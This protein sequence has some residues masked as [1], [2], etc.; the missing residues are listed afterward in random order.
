VSMR[1]AV[2]SA[3]PHVIAESRSD[4]VLRPVE[5]ANAGVFAALAVVIVSVGA[6]L[7]HLGA[8]ELLSVVP[9][10]IVGLRNRVRAV[11]AAVIAAA[12]VA[13][14]VAG[15]TATIVIAGCAVLG[16]FCGIIRR[17]G[18][19][20]G[21]VALVAAGLAPVSAA[22]VVGVLYLFSAARAL[23]FGTLRTS[24]VGIVRIAGSLRVPAPIG[25]AVMS[26]TDALLGA[27]PIAVAVVVLIAVPVGMLLTNA[28]VAGVARRV[29]WLA[30]T[31]LLDHAARTDAALGEAVAPVPLELAGVGFRHR[32]SGRDALV[33]VDLT[34]VPGEFIAVVGPNGAGKSTLVSLLAGAEPT[35]GRVR[36]PGR[37][38][39][40]LPGGT[41]IVAQRAETQVIGSTVGEDLRWGLP[42]G[43]PI[44][45]EALLA[46]VGLAGL[47]AASTESLSGGQ[48]Q[49]LAIATA[50]A[51]RP[52]LLISDEST[53]MLDAAGRAEVLDLLAA[54]PARTGTAV[55][56]VTHDPAEAARADRVI[57]LAD[58]RIVDAAAA[59]HG[60]I[61][62]TNDRVA[63]LA[64]A[65]S[66]AAYRSLA[67]WPGYT[68]GA[69]GEP[70]IRVRGVGHRFDAGTPWEVTALRS[71]DLD[72]REGEGLLITGENG[73]GKS[74][75]A[76]VLA[77]LIRPT[78]GT[79]TIDGAPA[80][81]SVG[82]VALSFQLARLQ[83]QRPTV[84]EDILA[85][86]GF[87]ATSAAADADAFVRTSLHRVGLPADLAG[88]TIDELSG[89]QMRR[90]AIAGLLASRPRVLILDEP[91]AGLDRESRRGLIELLGRMRRE[92]GLTLVVISHDFEDVGLACTRTI[93][94]IAGT[95]VLPGASAEPSGAPQPSRP[96][97]A[98]LVF[99]AVPGTSALHRLGAATKLLAMA[100]VTITS[101][102]L[103]GWPT[104]A[105][106]TILLVAGAAAARLPRTV[107][108]R[109]SWWVVAIV[110]L[111]GVTAAAGSGIVLY[112]RSLLLTVLFLA[113]SLLVVWTTRVEELPAA[114]AR[115]ARPLRKLGAPVDE[116]AHTLALAVRTLPL[117]RDEFRVLIAGRR[118]R[119]S[120]RA[121][122]RWARIVARCRELID[123]VVAIVASAGRRASDLGR[124]ATQ[125]GGMRS[126]DG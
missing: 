124:A 123:L 19:G 106:L 108:P 85:A 79:A 35:S 59:G 39:L 86:A 95:V 27:W 15:A 72:V 41:T 48:L 46:W 98:G 80:S 29:E 4:G 61:D 20:S 96:R 73:S 115:I 100:A 32:T 99:R 76:W 17:H 89:G 12:F 111:G 23:A 119:A 49:R 88:R 47:A 122:G 107:I 116:W 34:V 102:L 94:V 66:R 71:V 74:T 93:E 8:I 37:V 58:G 42:P 84:A 83:L 1:S 70:V 68:R 117:L 126:V 53:S 21:T 6:F 31:D 118:L 78:E 121:T 36:R 75:L 18:R 43:Y 51:R 112:T 38:G 52:A 109:I 97:R 81:A 13:F 24:V 22:V 67:P 103:P 54:L 44:D 90:V 64:T 87:D 45:V 113:L 105:V 3:S 91:F 125:R 14:L 62:S 110:L 9:F 60:V 5:I 30:H 7:P 25:H 10:A 114:F 56:H 101:L 63:P 77:G 50:M 11:V 92:E 57:G 69:S 28:V 82:A 120:P 33:D 16:G 40:G 2:R 26:I 65:V 55:V 104:I